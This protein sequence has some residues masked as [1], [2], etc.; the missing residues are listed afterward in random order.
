M[1]YRAQYRANIGVFEPMGRAGRPLLVSEVTT[2]D[3]EGEESIVQQQFAADSDINVIMRR[4]G[5]TGELP[6]RVDMGLF[7][8]FTEIEDFDSAVARVDRARDEFYKL[9]AEVRERFDNDPGEL[10]KRAQEIG[11][12]ALQDEV[13]PRVVAPEAPVVKE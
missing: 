12:V 5:A 10:Y 6:Y 1:D 11:L 2:L 13:Y 3:Q 7:G 8:D 9:P 4:F